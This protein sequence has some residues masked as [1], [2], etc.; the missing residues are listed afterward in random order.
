MCEVLGSGCNGCVAR[1]PAH[2]LRRQPASPC[3]LLPAGLGCPPGSLACGWRS[4]VTHQPATL[5]P[6]DST[7]LEAKVAHA[8]LQLLLHVAG[9]VLLGCG[10]AQRVGKW[11]GAQAVECKVAQRGRS[12]AAR[13][14]RQGCRIVWWLLSF[15]VFPNLPH[16]KANCISPVN[17]SSSA[18]RGTVARTCKPHTWAVKLAQAWQQKVHGC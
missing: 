3:S 9:N 14:C 4:A 7:H 8:L 11:E 12:Q 16:S 15:S 17:T 13:L 18:M 1:Q 5:L 2:L 10:A 6:P